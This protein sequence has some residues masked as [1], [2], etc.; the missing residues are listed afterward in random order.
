MEEGEEDGCSLE[1]KG[2]A[3]AAVENGAGL[4]ALVLVV[5]LCVLAVL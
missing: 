4:L 1:F 5:Y 2:A 3:V